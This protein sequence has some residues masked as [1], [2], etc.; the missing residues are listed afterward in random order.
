MLGMLLPVLTEFLQ[1]SRRWVLYLSPFRRQEPE[2]QKR[3]ISSL[4]EELGFELRSVR[5]AI[6]SYLRAVCV[7]VSGGRSRR[8]EEPTLASSGSAGIPGVPLG[9]SLERGWVSGLGG[10]APTRY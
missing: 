5:F 3:K 9:C 1:I 6:T 4:G 7:C 8:G 10:R 2:A